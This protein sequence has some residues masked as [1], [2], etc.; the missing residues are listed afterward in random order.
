[1]LDVTAPEPLPSEHPFWVHPRIFLTPYVA[2]MTQPETAAPVVLKN[3]RR[4][5]RGEALA[6]VIDWSRGY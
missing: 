5:R 4:H 6:N 2:S 3:L 1:M